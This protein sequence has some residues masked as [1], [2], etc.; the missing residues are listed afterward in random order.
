LDE[1]IS[2]CLTGFALIVDCTE[3]TPSERLMLFS[4]QRGEEFLGH[5]SRIAGHCREKQQAA[6]SN[7]ALE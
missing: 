7:A 2:A 3:K 5:R 1:A 4:L 6:G